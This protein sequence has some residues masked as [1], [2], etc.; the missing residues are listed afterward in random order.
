MSY[1]TKWEKNLVSSL[2]ERYESGNFNCGADVEE[3]KS[4]CCAK[5]IDTGDTHL[6]LPCNGCKFRKR[7]LK[8]KYKMI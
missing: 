5:A 2:L 3:M 4:V 7:F 8:L 1:L 6:D